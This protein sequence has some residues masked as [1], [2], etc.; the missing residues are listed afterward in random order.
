LYLYKEDI[1]ELAA[2]KIEYYT[3]LVMNDVSL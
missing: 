1:L 2:G 3:Y